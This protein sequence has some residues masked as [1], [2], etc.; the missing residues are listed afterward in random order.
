[1][2]MY[3]TMQNWDTFGTLLGQNTPKAMILSDSTIVLYIGKAR[4][5]V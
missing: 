4:N 5:N 1:M 3:R 2:P